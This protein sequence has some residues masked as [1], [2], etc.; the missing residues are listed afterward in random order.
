MR[1]F[2]AHRAAQSFRLPHAEA[3]KR[4]RHLEHLVLE[5]DD[6]ERRA[7]AV[8]EQRMIHRRDERRVL[9][10]A[11]AVIDV[12]MD[13]LALNRARTH[14]RDLDGEI[15]DVLRTRAQQALHLRPALDLEVA[16]RVGALD[17][18][19]DRLVVER[20]PGKVDRLAA[21]S[22]DLV[23]AVLDRRE[24]SEPEQVDLEET[25]VGA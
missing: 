15:V 13:G 24:H 3:G 17:L 14:E 12:R 16:D 22:R 7:Q 10:Q 8:R 4:D 18:L 5:D 25:G 9:A 20:D 21:Q 6:P 19:V 2:A 23:D 11:L 1:A